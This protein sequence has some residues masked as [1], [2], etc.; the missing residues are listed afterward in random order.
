MKENITRPSYKFKNVDWGATSFLL[1]TPFFSILLLPIYFYFFDLTWPIVVSAI[2]YLFF[3]NL[4]I[5]AGYHR[6]YAHRS[7]QAQN[8]VQVFLLFFGAGAF[9]NSAL[10]WASDHRFHHKNV[11]FDNDPYSISKG[12]FYAHFGWMLLNEKFKNKLASDL[13]R[14]KWVMLQH[15]YYV[16]IAIFTG[17][18]LPTLWGLYLGDAWGGFLFVGLIRIVLGHH[19]T[20]LVNSLCHMAGRQPYSLKH[21][22]RDNLLVAFLTNGEGY[23][24]FH[25]SFEGDYRNGVRWYQWDPTK[26]T[27]RAMSWMGWTYKLR[28]TSKEAILKSRLQVDRNRLDKKGIDT[29]KLQQLQEQIELVM[30]RVNQLKADYKQMKI[31]CKKVTDEWESQYRKKAI[32]IKADL[33]LAKLELQNRL[34]QWSRYVNIMSAVPA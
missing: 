19:T 18:F 17:F 25:H 20:F 27:I 31:D 6:L 28:R 29:H 3:M 11:D 21:S 7:F 22:A 5:T 8:W 34:N 14:N 32:E 33:E 16:A 13:L 10:K 23:H 1:L 24:N 2:F 26:W 12:G 30:A 9:Q 4:T 15:N